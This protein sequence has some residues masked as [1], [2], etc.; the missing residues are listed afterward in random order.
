MSVAAESASQA[1]S[2]ALFG[3]STGPVQAATSAV[4]EQVEAARDAVS[5]ALFGE[6]EK[7]AMESAASRI[8]EAVESAKSRMEEL[9]AR[10]TEVVVPSDEKEEEAVHDEL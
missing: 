1:I 7:G 8:S 3:T 6:A 4:A 10:A 2:E 5:S 9:A